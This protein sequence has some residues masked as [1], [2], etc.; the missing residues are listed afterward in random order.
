MEEGYVEEMLCDQLKDHC[1]RIHTSKPTL[2]VFSH[3]YRQGILDVGK[4]F[5]LRVLMSDPA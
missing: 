5:Y 1:F 3:P 4:A 2:Y